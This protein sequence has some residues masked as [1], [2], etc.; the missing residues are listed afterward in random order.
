MSSGG[1]IPDSFLDSLRGLVVY[2]NDHSFAVSGDSLADS[3]SSSHARSSD[4]VNPTPGSSKDGGSIIPFVCNLVGVFASSLPSV[5][6]SVHSA[7]GFGSVGA[8][9]APPPGFAH[10]PSVASS[11]PPRLPVSSA[12]VP[13]SFSYPFPPSA[14]PTSFAHPLP[15][16]YP[17]T[18]PV[19]P[20]VAPIASLPFFP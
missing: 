5:V 3:V 12:A 1:Y 11:V 2:S 15:S 10:L 13:P 7:G 8:L 16:L 17:I 18:S 19:T 14:P 4:P 6:G 9:P 20:S